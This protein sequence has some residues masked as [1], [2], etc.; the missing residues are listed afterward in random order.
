MSVWTKRG[1]REQACGPE[2]TS[3][4]GSGSTSSGGQPQRQRKHSNPS[5]THRGQ[6]EPLS[7]RVGG[8]L[9]TGW[10]PSKAPIWIHLW[11]Q[12]QGCVS[13]TQAVPSAARLSVIKSKQSR[14]WCW[15]RTTGCRY[16]PPAWRPTVGKKMLWWQSHRT[17]LV[18]AASGLF[19]LIQCVS[20]FCLHGNI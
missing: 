4:T 5:K 8:N 19:E 2:H 12:K 16:L 20:T 7:S 13:N 18:M 1:Q 10:S 9:S 11:G 15:S 17:S 6:G 14:R 3:A